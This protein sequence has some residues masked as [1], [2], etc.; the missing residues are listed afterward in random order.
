MFLVDLKTKKTSRVGQRKY[1]LFATPEDLRDNPD[2]LRSGIEL[3]SQD[4]HLSVMINTADPVGNALLREY[5]TRSAEVRW[6]EWWREWN[7]SQQDRSYLGKEFETVKGL[8][9]EL[10]ALGGQFCL[11]PDYAPENASLR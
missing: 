2:M 1:P 10:R 7:S 8:Y 4:D 11:E 6:A 3:V 5:G 9:F